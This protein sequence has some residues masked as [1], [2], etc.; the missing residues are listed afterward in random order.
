MPLCGEE[1]KEQRKYTAEQKRRSAEKN[2]LF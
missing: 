1:R 2:S